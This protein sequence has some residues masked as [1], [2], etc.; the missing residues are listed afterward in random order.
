MF[1][2]RMHGCLLIHQWWRV[3]YTTCVQTV[4]H[5]THVEQYYADKM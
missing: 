1:N 2:S 5:T 3:V 4:K